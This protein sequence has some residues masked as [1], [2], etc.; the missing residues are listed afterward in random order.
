M[1]AGTQDV[2][3]A[4]DL[5]SGP[6]ARERARLCA[7]TRTVHPVSELIR[8]VVGPNGEAVPD[9]KSKLPGRGI[10]VTATRDAMGEAIKRK[11]FARGFKRDV[12]LPPDLVDWNERSL[13]PSPSPARPAWSR[14]ASARS[15]RPLKT[16]KWPAFYMLPRPL[17]TESA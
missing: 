3:L 9:V 13:T 4:A 6:R 5:D 14:P 16:K 10:W 8:F 12:R 11:V 17:P 2:E 7:A 1:I 15:R